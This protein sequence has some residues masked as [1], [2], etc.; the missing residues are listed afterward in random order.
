MKTLAVVSRKGGSGKS[1]LARAI[2]VEAL[3]NRKRAAII[4]TDEQGTV[5]LWGKRRPHGAPT[6][7]AI[8]EGAVEK[9]LAALKKAKAEIV[10]IDTPPNVAPIINIAIQQADAAVIVSG[11]YPEDLEQV[12]VV[13]EMLRR[14]KK[15]TGIV[16]NRVPSGAA[17]LNAARNALTTFRL[18][19][20]PTAIYQRVTHPYA[21]AEGLTASER[22]P[23]GK[24]A[25]ELHKM[26]A[27]LEKEGFV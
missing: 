19:I 26:Y 25:D 12:G 6:I 16:L 24:A 8:N 18:P 4:D 23:G 11:V 7:L 15:P 14:L 20:C 1:H 2:S 27:W 5:V 13:A 10:L 21:S 17:A 22:E 9:H 3:L